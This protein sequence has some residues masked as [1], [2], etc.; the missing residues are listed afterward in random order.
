MIQISSVKEED[1]LHSFTNHLWDVYHESQTMLGIEDI[2]I[3]K[4][5]SHPS[6]AQMINEDK[7]GS[8]HGK[9]KG[10][11]WGASPDYFFS[12]QTPAE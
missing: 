8:K 7:Q 9:G 12:V 11:L 10:Q 3:N 5:N 2:N 1:E 6:G 4:I